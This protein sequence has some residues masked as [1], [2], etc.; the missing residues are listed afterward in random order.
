MINK[1]GKLIC[2]H[3]HCVLKQRNVVLTSYPVQFQYYCPK[4]NYYETSYTNGLGENI[5]EING[6]RY[7]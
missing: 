6:K 2:P 4:C 1:D 3:C 5:N 7:E